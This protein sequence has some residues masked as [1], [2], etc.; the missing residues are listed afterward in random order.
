MILPPLPE[1]LFRLVLALI[2][3]AVVGIEREYR[4]KNAGFRTMM[5][6]SLGAAMFTMLSIAV[7]GPANGDRIAANIAT[8]VGFLGAGV[9]FRSGVGVSGITTA[10]SIWAVAAIGMACGVGYYWLGTG[11]AV[12]MLIVL[13]LL[14]AIQ[15]R[16]DRYHQTRRYTI[17]ESLAEDN[18]D[19]LRERLNA[20]GLQGKRLSIS[21][22]DD[23]IVSIWQV[24]GTEVA[25]EGFTQASLHDSKFIAFEG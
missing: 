8:G 2:L 21:R 17:T 7:G 12:A 20:F 4:S 14:P 10:A 11:A 25:H 23:S 16:I 6:I 5:L 22:G 24:N 19:Y 18:P 13:S 3:G 15:R 1:L 9:I